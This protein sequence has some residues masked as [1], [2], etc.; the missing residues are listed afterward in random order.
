M[1]EERV[2]C[3]TCGN[4]APEE[5]QVTTIFVD[6][7]GRKEPVPWEPGCLIWTIL[8]IG[9]VVAF[10]FANWSLYSRLV[11][12]IPSVLVLLFTLLLWVRLPKLARTHLYHCKRCGK[13][14]REE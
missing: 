13:Q 2:Q 14:W 6:A 11:A 3:P 12:L 1:T 4:A 9:G 7:R 5:V 8:A 10:F